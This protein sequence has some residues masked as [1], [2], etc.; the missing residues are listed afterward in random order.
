[1]ASIDLD[2]IVRKLASAGGEFADIFCE[3]RSG[4]TLIHEDGRLDKIRKGIDRGVGLRTIRDRRTLYAYCTEVTAQAMEDMAA[5]LLTAAGEITDAPGLELVARPVNPVSEIRFD[6]SEVELDGKIAL[7]AE[8]D[9]SARSFGSEIVQVRVVF[10][11]ERRR[12]V[13]ANSEGY[14]IENG[15]QGPPVRGA[16]L[17]GNG[18]QVLKSIDMVG[19]DLGF[20]IGTCGK[21]GQGVPVSDAQP[22]LRIG[23]PDRPDTWIT[24]GGTA[25]S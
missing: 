10:S 22:T 12:L 4:V 1:M 6:P 16:T 9:D 13:Q 8:A 11:D 5:A 18:P 14:L 21:D 7:L 25:S 23:T 3:E 15:R 24:V 2:R 19:Y 20:A 17:V